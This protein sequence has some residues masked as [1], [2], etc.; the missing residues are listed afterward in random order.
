M[1]LIH[2]RAEP[3]KGS[4][5]PWLTMGNHPTIG[6]TSATTAAKKDSN[7]GIEAGQCRYLHFTLEKWVWPANFPRF[8]PCEATASASPRN[9]G[10]N[11]CQPV[12]LVGKGVTQ[13]KKRASQFSWRSRRLPETEMLPLLLIQIFCCREFDAVG[14]IQF[15]PAPLMCCCSRRR[16]AKSASPVV[17]S[18]GMWPPLGAFQ[19]QF[20]VWPSAKARVA[21]R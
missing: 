5:P 11:D 18:P 8:S 16:S 6:L 7:T 15:P 9:P 3:R 13:V 19:C 17:W 21:P 1:Y 20:S 2:S 10:M 4:P 14:R 12:G